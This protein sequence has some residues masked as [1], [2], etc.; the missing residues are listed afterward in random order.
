[1]RSFI[2]AHIRMLGAASAVILLVLAIEGRFR[3]R[4][5]RNRDSHGRERRDARKI[6]RRLHECSLLSIDALSLS[7]AESAD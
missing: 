6:D 2:A 4:E 5:L 1:M 3:R 7:D